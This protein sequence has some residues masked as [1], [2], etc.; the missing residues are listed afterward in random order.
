MTPLDH[1]SATDL[2][3]RIAEIRSSFDGDAWIELFTPDVVWH[4][5]PFAAPHVG[6]NAVRALLLEAS[7]REEQVEFTFERHWVVPPTILAPWHAS[8]VDRDRRARVRTAGF[9]ALEVAPDGRIRLARWW[10]VHTPASI[11]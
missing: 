2:L 4:E 7:R 1:A 3:E 9:V 10:P 8:H 11:E 5:R 6:L